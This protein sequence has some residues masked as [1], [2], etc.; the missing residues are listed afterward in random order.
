MSDHTAEI[1]VVLP[2]DLSGEPDAELCEKWGRH[3]FTGNRLVCW[4]LMGHKGD[5]FDDERYVWWRYAGD[6]K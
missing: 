3:L 2:D 1:I 6:D 4:R 5:H